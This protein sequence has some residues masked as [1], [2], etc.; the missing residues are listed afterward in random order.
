VNT[1]IRSIERGVFIDALVVARQ[2]CTRG[3]FICGLVSGIRN[4]TTIVASK[5]M[6]VMQRNPAL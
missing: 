2:C 6:A 4:K 3:G 1:V 5:A